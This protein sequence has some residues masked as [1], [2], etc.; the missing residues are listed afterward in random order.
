MAPC[1]KAFNFNNGIE[2]SVCTCDSCFTTTGHRSSPQIPTP[3]IMGQGASHQKDR[4][5]SARR[6][7]PHAGM[8]SLEHNQLSTKNLVRL[9]EQ[10][11]SCGPSNEHMGIFLGPEILYFGGQETAQ[12][13]F[14]FGGPDAH[15]PSNMATRAD[16]KKPKSSQ[17][18]PASTAQYFDSKGN[19]NHTFDFRASST[20]GHQ[21][22]YSYESRTMTGTPERAVPN[23]PS[24]NSHYRDASFSFARQGDIAAAE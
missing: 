13:V 2:S 8:N 18:P 15:Y 10:T 19:D 16:Q 4:T 5:G 20:G 17:D 22:E 7:V 9:D 21:D 1:Q 12:H 6:I 3:Q 14:N 24:Q 23:Y 11:K